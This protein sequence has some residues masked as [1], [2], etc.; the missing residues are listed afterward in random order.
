MMKQKLYIGLF[1]ALFALFSTSGRAQ[2]LLASEAPIDVKLKAIDSLALQKQ[3]EAEYAEFPAYDLY[4]EWVHNTVKGVKHVQI[5]DSFDIDMR[6][7]CMPTTHT[8]ITSKFGPRRRRMHYGLDVKVYTGDTIR[9]AFGGRVR[10]ARY[11]RRGYGHYIVIRHDNGL[12]TIYG[13]LSKRLVKQDTFVKA[14]D[15]IGLGGNT[16][17]STGSHLHFECRFLGVAINPEKLFDFPHQ[18]IV[19][20]T[21]HFKKKK[22]L[23]AV[24]YHKVR[25]GDSL[26]KIAS[27]YGVS[28]SK[29]CRMNGIKRSAILRIGQI[30]RCS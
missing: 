1:F 15:V 17:R 28:I 10:M 7:F 20:D 30:I 5:P 13:H 24:R 9:A 4:P 12:E 25:R 29:L 14:G 22:S 8:R 3:I 16:G 21:Y 23:A 27:R 2:D 19:A 6:G 26:G 18:D 11:Q